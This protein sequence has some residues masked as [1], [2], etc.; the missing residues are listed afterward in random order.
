MENMTLIV[1]D[2]SLKTGLPDCGDTVLMDLTKQGI[3]NCMGC[4]GCWTKTPGR[5]VIRDDAVRIY[6]LIARSRRLLYVTRVRY[7]GYDV[8]MKTLLER[9]IPVQQPFIRIVDGET[10]HVQRTVVPKEAVILAYGTR[11]T[12]ERALF[13]RL[14]DRNA[15]NM[16]FA[17]WRVVFCDETAVES[18]LRKELAAWE[19]S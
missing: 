5:C 18:Q 19:N 6:P 8:P 12:E 17:A 10:H 1:S 3:R 16:N 11:D 14:T 13:R 2:R 9:C 15:R 4:F 7:G